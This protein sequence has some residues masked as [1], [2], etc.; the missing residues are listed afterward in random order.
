MKIPKAYKVG[1]KKY[2]LTEW[3]NIFGP[4]AKGRIFYDTGVILLSTHSGYTNKPLSVGERDT[5]F[6]H[7]TVHA[8]L[9]DMKSPK[10]RDEVFVEGMARRLEQIVRT[11]EF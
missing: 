6:W 5:A 3:R 10:N 2:Q 1:K 4:V 11:A 9:R 7:E 8:I